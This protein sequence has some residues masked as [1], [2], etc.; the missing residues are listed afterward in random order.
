MRARVRVVSYSDESLK[1]TRKPHLYLC[2]VWCIHSSPAPV[3]LHSASP[4]LFSHAVVVYGTVELPTSFSLGIHSFTSLQLRLLSTCVRVRDAGITRAYPDTV[5][6]QIQLV[7]RRDLRRNNMYRQKSPLNSLDGG[8]LTLAPI[9]I[10]HLL[11]LYRE[12][13]YFCVENNFYTPSH[14]HAL[15]HTHTLTHSHA[16]SHTLSHTHTHTHTHS[17]SH[18]HAHTEKP[19]GNW[20]R[21]LPR[22]C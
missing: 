1:G 21:C 10:E 12:Y 2:R 14:T 20:H 4:K 6:T 22:L 7:P 5:H 15:S 18:T 8:S 9:I 19:D 11:Q 17:L 3:S 13:I 16:H